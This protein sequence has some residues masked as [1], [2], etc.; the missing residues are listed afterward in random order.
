MISF[1]A[2]DDIVKNIMTVIKDLWKNMN[3]FSKILLIFGLIITSFFYIAA[4]FTF[5]TAGKIGDYYVL[6]RWCRDLTE[7]GKEMLSVT[8]VPALLIDILHKAEKIPRT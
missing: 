4:A 1:S 2:G 5:L 6:M 7:C 8:L 3:L